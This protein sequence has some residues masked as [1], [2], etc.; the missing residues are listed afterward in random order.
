VNAFTQ[1]RHFTLS[2]SRIPW[3]INCNPE[4][5]IN[6]SPT[7]PYHSPMEAYWASKALS[8]IATHK[9]LAD[10]NPHFEITNL[11][12][13]VVIGPD[14]LATKTS[15]LLTG[16]RALA[17][18]PVLGQKID[19]PLV[20]VQVHVD[21]VARAH[22]DA[23]DTRVPG[24][25]D[26]ILTSNGLDGIEWDDAKGMFKGKVGEGKLKLSLD[27]SLPTTKW[28]IDGSKTEEAFGW[29]CRPFEETMGDLVG[30]YL[31]LLESESEKPTA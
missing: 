24:N 25:A 3:L 26:Y 7:T 8:R 6:S 21:D 27:G 4:R 11:L 1:V 22:V 5:D 29:K 19:S 2:L 9:F 14:G 30:Q 31:G 13:T 12:P 15:E 20:G 17:L 10:R 16:T 18:A 23:L 28:K